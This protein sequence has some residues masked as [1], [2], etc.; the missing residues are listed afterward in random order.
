MASSAFIKKVAIVGAGGNVGRFITNALL[1]TGKHDVTAISRFDSQSKLPEGVAVS[2]V[3]YAKPATLV[4]ALRGQDALVITMGSMADKDASAKLINAASEA[5]V[6]WILPNEWSPDSDNEGLVKDVFIYKPKA[7]IR[8]AIADLGNTSYIGVSTGFWYEWS[9][10]SP[11]SYGIDL[12]NHKATLFDEGDVKISTTTWPQVGR[13]VA[14]LL[15]LPVSAQSSNAEASLE[16]YKNKMIYIK[17]FTVSQ[18]DMLESAFRVTGTKEEDWTITKE[19]AQERYAN[20]VK[21]FKEGNRAG[22]IKFMY[23]R[24]FYPDGSGD[25]EHSK[26][27]LNEVLGLPEEDIDKATMVTL[28]RAKGGNPFA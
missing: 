9:L 14:A 26:G 28:E 6:Q 27:T 21:E 8:K 7:D 25:T 22:F 18:R 24:I 10:A 11:L 17:S 5:G 3:D 16:N 23:T 13:A 12:V 2:R 20:G 4:D 15:S 19:P 1:K